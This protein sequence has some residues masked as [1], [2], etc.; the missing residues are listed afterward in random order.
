MH[1]MSLSCACVCAMARQTLM[2]ILVLSQGIQNGWQLPAP[3]NVDPAGLPRCERL[4]ES[5]AEAIHSFEHPPKG[6]L[7]AMLAL[8]TALAHQQSSNSACLPTCF[9]CIV[10]HKHVRIKGRIYSVLE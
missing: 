4:P 9:A 7:G 1:Y 5:L 6:C 10:M 3:C 8:A 2:C